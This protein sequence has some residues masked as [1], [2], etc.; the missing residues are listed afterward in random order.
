MNGGGRRYLSGPQTRSN[1]FS[2]LHS[3]KAEVRGNSEM[4]RLIN[5]QMF[6]TTFKSMLVQKRLEAKWNLVS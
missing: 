5:K 3:G 6:V 4:K 1:G 2:D